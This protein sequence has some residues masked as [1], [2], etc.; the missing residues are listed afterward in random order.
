MRVMT[1]QP[2][3]HADHADHVAGETAQHAA[4]NTQ[5]AL[6][7]ELAGDGDRWKEGP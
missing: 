3:D 1:V 7:G 4:V 6:H 5:E 2:P